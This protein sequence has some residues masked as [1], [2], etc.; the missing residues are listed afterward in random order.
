ME[1]PVKNF[2]STPPGTETTDAFH[3]FIS[4]GGLAG[5]F[6][7]RGSRR[8]KTRTGGQNLNFYIADTFTQSRWCLP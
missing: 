1:H 8:L 4:F 6:S 2:Q 5:L 3:K 7:D